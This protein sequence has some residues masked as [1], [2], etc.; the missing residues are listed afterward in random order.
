MVYYLSTLHGLF[1]GGKESVKETIGSS[2]LK[3]QLM[4][5]L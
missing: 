3:I 4:F 1:I 2:L 5:F